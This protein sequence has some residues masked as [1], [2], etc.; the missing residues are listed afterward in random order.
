MLA[1][2]Y[3]RIHTHFLYLY[4]Y[5]YTCRYT[6]RHEINLNILNR[7]VASTSYF[8]IFFRWK[9]ISCH[10]CKYQLVEIDMMMETL[11][12]IFSTHKYQFEPFENTHTHTHRHTPHTMCLFWENGNCDVR[13]LN[14]WIFLWTSNQTSISFPILFKRRSFSRSLRISP[15]RHSVFFWILFI[16]RYSRNFPSSVSFYFFSSSS[17]SCHDFYLTCH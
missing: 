10:F 17:S 8:G 13:Q 16:L 11:F 15:S 3:A 4:L 9:S 1:Q 5:L 7:R 6:H 12:R 2:K 14:S